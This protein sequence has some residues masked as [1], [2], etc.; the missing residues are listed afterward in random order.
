MATRMQPCGSTCS[1]RAVCWSG[2]ETL[3]PTA[4]PW[5]G[6][7]GQ[8]SSRG[9]TAA[10]ECVPVLQHLL[11]DHLV[12]RPEGTAGTPGPSAQPLLTDAHSG[13]L[14]P[15]LVLYSGEAEAQEAQAFLFSS[16]AS[17][18]SWGL[19]S[20]EKCNLRAQMCGCTECAW[21]GARE[22][23]A[24]DVQVSEPDRGMGSLL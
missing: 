13:S 11:A 16:P 23:A 8:R 10:R 12:L 2:S 22:L 17:S 9:S 4:W 14:S 18:F 24:R 19:S 20:W 7:P 15:F 3:W 21:G 6:P 1:P 5:M